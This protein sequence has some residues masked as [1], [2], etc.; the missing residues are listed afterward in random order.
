MVRRANPVLGNAAQPPRVIVDAPDFENQSSQRLNKNILADRLATR[1]QI[2]ANGRILFVNR[3]HA[4]MVTKERLLKREG[5]TDIGTTSWRRPSAARSLETRSARARAASSLPP[6]ELLSG[7]GADVGRSLDRANRVYEARLQPRR[8]HSR[9]T[10]VPGFAPAAGGSWFGGANE[11]VQRLHPRRPGG[12]PTKTAQ[13]KRLIAGS[14]TP[15]LQ[16]ARG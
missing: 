15:Y 10:P 1:L 4:D 2:A 3:D 14:L 7:V 12:G 5:V 16:C 9:Q 13:R 8:G 6:R 11:D